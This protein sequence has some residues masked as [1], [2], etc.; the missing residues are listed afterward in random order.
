[1]D[2]NLVVA[3][4][5]TAVIML[6]GFVHAPVMPVVTGAAIACAWTLWRASGT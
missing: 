3:A 4:A 2:R 5:I 1:M 6:V